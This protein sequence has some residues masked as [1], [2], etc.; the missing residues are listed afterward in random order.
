MF[1]DNEVLMHM[2]NSSRTFTKIICPFIGV[3]R[4]GLERAFEVRTYDKYFFIYSQ[5][6]N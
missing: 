3:T 1:I 5:Y 2:I 4:D 6:F